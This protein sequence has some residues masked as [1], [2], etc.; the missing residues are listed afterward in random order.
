M[1]VEGPLQI[2][3][4]SSSCTKLFTFFPPVVFFVLSRHI[5]LFVAAA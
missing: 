5:A 4:V 2:Q 1:D 3:N